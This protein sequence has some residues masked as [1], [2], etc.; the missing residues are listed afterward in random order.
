MNVTEQT[1]STSTKLLIFVWWQITNP[2]PT[3]KN[4]RPIKALIKHESSCDETVTKK[5]YITENST[6][7][8]NTNFLLSNDDMK[9]QKIGT[10][11]IGTIKELK[12]LSTKHFNSS[13]VSIL[14]I[15]I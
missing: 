4:I 13:F 2:A 10:I 14:F 3:D 15:T 12:S 9:G 11:E 6:N 8:T 1:I 7:K 5:L